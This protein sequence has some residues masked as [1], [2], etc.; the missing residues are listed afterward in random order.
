MLAW[1]FSA[2]AGVRVVAAVTVQVLL[3]LLLSLIWMIEVVT[4]VELS[5][6]FVACICIGLLADIIGVDASKSCGCCCLSSYFRVVVA[7]LLL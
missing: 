2:I 3:L 7:I 4:V 5:S 6:C 1:P